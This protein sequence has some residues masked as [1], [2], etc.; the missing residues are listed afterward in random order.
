MYMEAGALFP[1]IVDMWSKELMGGEYGPTADE[2]LKSF[3]YITSSDPPA[4][5]STCKESRDEG[6]DW[7]RPSFERTYIFNRQPKPVRGFT[8][9]LQS[10]AFSE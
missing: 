1:R 7:Y 8:S 3:Q 9:I 2:H 6:L 4:I 10:I 5:L